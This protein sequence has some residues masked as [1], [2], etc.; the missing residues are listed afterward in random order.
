MSSK[1]W[2]W[3]VLIHL[4]VCIAWLLLNINS[5]RWKAWL[6]ERHL[7]SPPPPTSTTTSFPIT[8]PHIHCLVQVSK[9][10]HTTQWPP[11]LILL[12]HKLIHAYLG[13]SNVLTAYIFFSTPLFFRYSFGRNS[14]KLKWRDAQITY[15]SWV[16]FHIRFPAKMQFHIT[17]PSPWDGHDI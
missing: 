2:I 3:H 11:Y 10:S 16:R 6:L 7:T 4:S 12:T 14:F 1:W 13:S 15:Y 8:Y 9:V 5:T 17:L